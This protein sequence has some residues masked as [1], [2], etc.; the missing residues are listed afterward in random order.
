MLKGIK[1]KENN[2][3]IIL[4]ELY[5]LKKRDARFL[6]IPNVLYARTNTTSHFKYKPKIFYDYFKYAFKAAFT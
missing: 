4:E 3:S 5:Y 6:E 2:F 1:F